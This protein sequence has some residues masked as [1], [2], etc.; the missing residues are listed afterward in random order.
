[1]DVVGKYK[2][3]VDFTADLMTRPSGQF[4]RHRVRSMLVDTFQ[5]RVS[6]NWQ[7]ADGAFGHELSHPIPGWPSVSDLAL[8]ERYLPTHPLLCWFR[9]TG[10]PRPWTV[11]RVPKR[12]VPPE[13]FVALR[14]LCAPVG[15]DEQLSIPYQLSDTAYR[16]FVL[17]RTGED[18]SDEDVELA[19]RIQ[20]LVAALGKQCA[21]LLENAEPNPAGLTGRELGVLHLLRQGCTARAIG[22]RLGISTRT[23]HSHLASVYRKLGVN[24]RLQAVMVAQRLGLSGTEGEPSERPMG[25]AHPP[26]PAITGVIPDGRV[27]A[28]AA[29]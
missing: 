27:G 10:D 6:W 22:H 13:G 1:M 23:V 4:P 25:F 28:L 19:R 18:F 20:P 3:W 5:T 8:W 21:L 29:G 2:V 7:N 11:G 26:P 16:A 24:D 14:E 12:L 15:V 17:A 9:A